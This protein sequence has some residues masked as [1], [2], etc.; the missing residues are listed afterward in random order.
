MRRKTFDLLLLSGLLLFLLPILSC[1]G[2]KETGVEEGREVAGKVLLADQTGPT[3]DHSGI[4]VEVEGLGIKTTTAKDGSF[5]LK[6]LSEGAYTLVFSKEGYKT[7]KVDLIIQPGASP[8]LEP[9]SLQ[10][11]GAIKGVVRLSDDANPEG[12]TLT[13]KELGISTKAGKDGTF[14]FSSVEPGS[15]TILAER[16]AYASFEL[17]V[18]VKPHEETIIGQPIILMRKGPLFA[19]DFSSG[20]LTNWTIVDD[21]DITSGPSAWSVV[22]GVLQQSSNIWG[23]TT[24]EYET[25]VGTHVWAGS[26]DWQDYT[27]SVRMRATD[28]DG[29][30]VLFRYQDEKHYYRFFMVNDPGNR[31]PFSR[32]DKNIDGTFTELAKDSWCY[33][34][35]DTWYKVR[36]ELKGTNI[37][38]YVDDRLLFDVKD[39]TYSKGAIG[40]MCYAQAGAFFDDVLVE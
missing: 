22:G 2:K 5:V 29:F 19:D 18:E 39:N 38:V 21:Q 8:T 4:E 15:Y 30:G 40:L 6:G 27:F 3:A 31:G 25:F 23:T 12:T 26:K 14:E 37:K 7:V 33:T 35:G 24:N 34:P 10:P 17:S 13:L 1:A 36:V 9:I 20:Q 28:N 32:L 16:D 11:V